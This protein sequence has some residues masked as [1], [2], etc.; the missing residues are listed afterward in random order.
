M[1]LVGHRGARFEAPENTL[2]G[3]RYAIGLG[4]PAVE[5]DIRMSLDG[6]LVI[7]HDETVDRTTDGVGKVA[8]LTL[9]ELK[10]LDARSIHTTWSDACRIPTFDE[11]L[12]VVGELPVILVEIKRDTPE[13]LDVIVPKTIEA[14][15]R[16]DLEHQAL[17]I[18]FEPYALQLARDGAPEIVRGYI[19]NWDTSAFLDRARELRCGWV[20]PYHPTASRELV[21]QAKAEGFGVSSWPTNTSDDVDGVLALDPDELTSD[22]PTT[23]IP[24][25]A[26]RGVTV[27]LR[28][29]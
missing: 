9:A 3:F 14:L 11:T 12:G 29:A 8:D 1:R 2:E 19:G 10:Q 13:R 17:I 26:S 18:S 23:I 6:E 5:F 22:A 4:L 15:R 16:H 28:D 20:N 24:M 25:L 21:A 27:E 7:M